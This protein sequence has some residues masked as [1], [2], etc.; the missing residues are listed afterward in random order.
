VVQEVVTL[1]LG[2]ISVTHTLKTVV[3]NLASMAESSQWATTLVHH[4]DLAVS[5]VTVSS[6]MTLLQLE[7]HSSE[8]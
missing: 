4:T 3:I 2:V 7:L 6:T 1:T 5:T 8:L